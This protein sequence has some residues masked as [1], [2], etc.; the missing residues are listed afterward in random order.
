MSPLRINSPMS[1]RGAKQ[2]FSI[3]L[4]QFFDAFLVWSGFAIASAVSNPVRDAL[5]V[6]SADDYA[7]EGMMWVIYIVV[8]LTPLILEKFGF[9]DR[10]LTKRGSESFNGLFRG[11]LIVV[12]IVGTVAVF[13]KF[14]DT[15]RLV[16]G[17]GLLFTFLLLW[18]RSLV[19]TRVL[20]ARANKEGYLERVVLAGSANETGKFLATLDPETS[21]AWKVVAEFDLEA[22]SIQELDDL[23][24][25]E[26][27]QR[28]IFLATHAEFERVARAVETCEVQ[29]V[30]AWIGASFLQTQVARPSFDSVNGQ[31]M[32]VF[33]ST[34]ELSW[35]LFAKKMVDIVGALVVIVGSSPLWI[36]AF[37]GIRLSSPGAP[38]IFTQQRAGLYGKPFKIYKFRTMVPDAEAQ[39]EK[40]KA[41]HGNEVDGPAFKL[42][43]DP[44]IF[45]FG[46]FLRKY[47]IDELPQMI[48]VLKGEMSLVGPRPL[49]LHEIEAIANSAHRRRLSMK[50]GVT[51]LWQISG[52]SDITN[53][54]EWVELDVAYIDRWSLWEDLKILLKTIPAV[55]FSKGAR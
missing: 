54:D 48:N 11:L 55:L 14:A 13:G 32:L 28:V 23:I 4:L 5:G 29:G 53:F 10:L 16:L 8:P 30:E 51:C 34:P 21:E 26:A 49:P 47:S 41:K 45:K 3:Q 35:Q 6:S 36:A 22:L 18:S 1:D 38:A 19:T 17:S 42:A 33:R 9:Y 50:P 12:L 15:R 44:R 2:L 24:K 40:I 37:I 25:T 43:T 39:L 46:S 52:R 7:L 31:P 27:V 20:R